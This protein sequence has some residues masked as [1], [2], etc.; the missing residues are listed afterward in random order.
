MSRGPA[1]K[2]EGTR[3]GKPTVDRPKILQ[4]VAC[5]MGVEPHE[6]EANV[7]VMVGRIGQIR[8]SRIACLCQTGQQKR[9]PLK[10]WE[11]QRKRRCHS[12]SA[13]KATKA[14]LV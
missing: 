3:K 2:P 10:G 1:K 9:Q 5:A 6:E 14:L 13:K 4:D 11:K 8:T 7:A 12:R